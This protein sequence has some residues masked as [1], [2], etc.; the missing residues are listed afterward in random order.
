VPALYWLVQL[1][2]VGL[3]GDRTVTS[4]VGDRSIRVVETGSFAVMLINKV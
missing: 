2:V 3:G 1:L 4:C